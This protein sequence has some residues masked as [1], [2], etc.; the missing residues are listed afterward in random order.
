MSETT[1]KWYVLRAVSG[2]ES[3]VKEYAD[4]EIRTT[5]LG[6][7]V[8]QILI[9]IEKVYQIRN[10]KKTT[11]ER[12]YLPGYVLVEA[13]MTNE[14]MGRLRNIPNVLGFLGETPG[15][16]PMPLRQAEV[17]RFLGAAD[18]MQEQG[19][20]LAIPY[21]VGESV[22]VNV[23]PFAGFSGDI[24]EVLNDKKK[25]KVNVKI[26]GRKTPVE[27]GFMQVEKE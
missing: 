22:K 26:F 11:K 12:N 24:E 13:N 1:M 5:D 19:E 18:E 3:K 25:L 16:K 23:G 7:Y 14:T 2:K 21:S 17:N 8:A 4:A 6:Q 15:G 20:D 10:G 9:P 27:L